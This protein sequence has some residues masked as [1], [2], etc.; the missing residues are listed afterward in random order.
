[1]AVPNTTTFSLQD[2]VDEISGA[3]TSLQDCVNDANSSSYDATYYTSPATSLLEFRNYA[4]VSELTISDS[5]PYTYDLSN[6]VTE[7]SV[8]IGNGSTSQTITY[9]FKYISTTVSSVVVKIGTTVQSIND[10]TLFTAT[11]GTS[12]LDIDLPY[13]VSNVGSNTTIVYEFKLISTTSGDS[14]PTT[15]VVQLTYN[16]NFL[17]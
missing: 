3:Q 2:V 9:S 16:Y 4:D 12:D 10:E 17:D 5:S 15:N 14:I 7:D 1:M 11:L 8:T 6:P 13:D